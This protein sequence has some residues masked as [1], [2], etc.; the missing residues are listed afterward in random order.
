MEG[1]GRLLQSKLYMLSIGD[2]ATLDVVKL[3]EF[4]AY[5]DGGPFGEVLL[6]KRYVPVGT[7][8]G[9]VLGRVKSLHHRHGA[10]AHLGHG[11]CDEGY[12]W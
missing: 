9:D 3:V 12:R 5:L 2:Y 8:D 10:L 7:K 4:G 11:R 1:Q 6:P